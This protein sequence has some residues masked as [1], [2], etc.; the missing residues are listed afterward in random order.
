MG[1][2]PPPSYDFFRNPHPPTKTD[3]TPHG[4]PPPSLKNE[5]LPSEKQTL[6]IET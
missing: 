3:A 6:P 4:A 1:V 5:A 2:P